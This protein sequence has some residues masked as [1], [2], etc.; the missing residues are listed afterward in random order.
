MYGNTTTSNLTFFDKIA[1]DVSI[2]VD[3]TWHF[4]KR[5]LSAIDF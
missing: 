1:F 4:I 2:I 3:T 5:R